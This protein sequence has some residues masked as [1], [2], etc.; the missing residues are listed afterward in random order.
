VLL[1][2]LLANSS[3]QTNQLNKNIT[4][5]LV[6]MAIATITTSIQAAAVACKKTAAKYLSSRNNF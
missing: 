6:N 4:Y 2:G 5:Y 3:V 1:S